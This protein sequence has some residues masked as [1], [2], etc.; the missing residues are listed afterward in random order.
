M[1][2][3]ER[4]EHE[5]V[6][7]A[8]DPAGAWYRWNTSTSGWDGPTTPPWPHEPGPHHDEAAI[9]AA[10]MAAGEATARAFGDASADPRNPA[11]TSSTNRVDSWWNREF[12]PFSRRRL[13]FGLSTLPLI[14]ALQELLFGAIG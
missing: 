3:I 11:G 9:V 12:P 1:E 14:A 5:G 4:R 6:W 8:R 10:A 2:I 13:V 7:W